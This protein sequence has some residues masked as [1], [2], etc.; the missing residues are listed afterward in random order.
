MSGCVRG[1]DGFDKLSV[2]V[3]VDIRLLSFSK[4]TGH[5]PQKEGIWN[6]VEPFKPFCYLYFFQLARIQTDSIVEK[7]KGLHPDV[8]FEIGRRLLCNMQNSSL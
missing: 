8:N 1:C 6:I 7:L 4:E 2:F 3:T 5:S